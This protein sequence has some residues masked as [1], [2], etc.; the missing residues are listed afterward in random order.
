MKKTPAQEW[1]A[2]PKGH[3]QEKLIELAKAKGLA[4]KRLRD[5]FK[6]NHTLFDSEEDFNGFLKTVRKL[7]TE[8]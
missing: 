7:R 8:S 6:D 4:P 1:P 5:L 3:P 2:V